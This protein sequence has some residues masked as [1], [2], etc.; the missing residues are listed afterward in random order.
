MSQHND[1]TG[2]SCTTGGE[3]GFHELRTDT[4]TLIIQQYRHTSLALSLVTG[5]PFRMDWIRAG[6]PNQAC[7]AS[8]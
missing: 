8:T 1:E 2:I 4:L 6:R 5:T 3:T 7:Y